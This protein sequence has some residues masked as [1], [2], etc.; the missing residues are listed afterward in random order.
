MVDDIRQMRVQRE[1]QK[2]S[3]L[4]RRSRQQE[5][6]LQPSKSPVLRI[7]CY[8]E[9]CVLE[10]HEGLKMPA[11]PAVYMTVLH[12]TPTSDEAQSC[13]LKRKG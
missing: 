13:A 2:P 6:N 3:G 11:V 1:G 10:A 9:P 12:T 8:A 7:G 4:L 5:R